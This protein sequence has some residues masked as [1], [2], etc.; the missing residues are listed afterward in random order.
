ML[1]PYFF[2]INGNDSDKEKLTKNLKIDV[3]FLKLKGIK[4]L[5]Y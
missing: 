1:R 5:L 3:W 4:D 2:T